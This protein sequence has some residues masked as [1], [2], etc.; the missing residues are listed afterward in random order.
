[1]QKKKNARQSAPFSGRKLVY[2]YP[3]LRG[4]DIACWQ[5]QVGGLVVDGYYKKEDAERCKQIQALN[6]LE[7][8]GIVDENVWNISFSREE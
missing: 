6:N 5:D 3:N 7:L 1:L 4:D 8:T 2:V